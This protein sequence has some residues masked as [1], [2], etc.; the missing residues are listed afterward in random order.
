MRKLGKA[1]QVLVA[2][3]L[4]GELVGDQRL[5]FEKRLVADA[6]LRAAAD[7]LCAQRLRIRAADPAVPAG[8]VSGD[9]AASVVQQVR[10]MPSRSDLVAQSTAEAAAATAVDYARHLMVAALVV[11]GFGLLFGLKV[12]VAPDTG[13][14][15]ATEQEL[16]DLDAKVKEMK[17]AELQRMRRNR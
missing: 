4:D 5:E 15:Q 12:L 16:L 7:S 17:T 3:Y 8:P 14:L 1:D 13:A 2:R 10:R 6:A 9:F 11:C